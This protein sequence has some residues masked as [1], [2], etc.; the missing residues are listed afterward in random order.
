MT[1][2]HRMNCKTEPPSPCAHTHK[3]P[4]LPGHEV[5]KSSELSRA[6]EAAGEQGTG[7]P[8]ADRAKPRGPSPSLSRLSGPSRRCVASSPITR[9]PGAGR[10]ASEGGEQPEGP[11]GFPHATSRVRVFVEGGAGAALSVHAAPGPRSGTGFSSGVARPPP[12]VCTRRGAA[13]PSAGPCPLPSGLGGAPALHVQKPTFLHVQDNALARRVCRCGPDPGKGL[14][15]EAS[16]PRP[17]ISSTVREL[18]RRG[19]GHCGLPVP[20]RWGNGRQVP[21]AGD[22]PPEPCPS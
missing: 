17:A 19:P 13:A 22:W 1:A 11:E 10:A 16:L 20:T 9:A 21:R 6:P 14:C 2:C 18:P 8:G 15:Q 3:G 12:S 7:V 4:R 5:A